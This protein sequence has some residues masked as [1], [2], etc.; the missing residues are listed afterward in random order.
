MNRVEG[1]QEK[2][3]SRRLLTLLLY[4]YSFGSFTEVEISTGTE[5]TSQRDVSDA[6]NSRHFDGHTDLNC[7][8]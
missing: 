4:F 8:R 1:E 7:L 5:T 3:Q 6:Q 2:Q